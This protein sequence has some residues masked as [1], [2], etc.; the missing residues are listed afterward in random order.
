MTTDELR[1]YVD[2]YRA[3]NFG[4]GMIPFDFAYHKALDSGHSP[5]AS[6]TAGVYAVLNAFVKYVEQKESGD[7]SFIIEL[8]DSS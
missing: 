3:E 1:W 7:G 2:A 4:G 6:Q 5:A 8:G